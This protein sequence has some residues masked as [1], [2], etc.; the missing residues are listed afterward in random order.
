MTGAIPHLRDEERASLLRLL[1]EHQAVFSMNADDLGRANVAPMRIVAD[2]SAPVRR[3]PY[4]LAPMER[5][6]VEREVERML[7][8]GV[9]RPSTSGWSSPLLMVKKPDGAPRVVVDFRGLNARTEPETFALPR[10]D[11]VLESLRGCRT[12]LRWTS[13]QRTGRRR[14]LRTARR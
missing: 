2:R 8:L 4:R 6:A 10:V 7:R 11:H 12:S 3:P 5:D 9:I 14:F 1:L 13:P